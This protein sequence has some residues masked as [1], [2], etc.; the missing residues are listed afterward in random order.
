MKNLSFIKQLLIHNNYPPE[1]IEFHIKKRLKKLRHGCNTTTN[2]NKRN[3]FICLPYVK[4]LESFINN[5]FKQHNTNV[6]YSTKNKLNNIIKL[7]KD[8]TKACDNMNVIYKIK[9]SASYVGQTG[10]RLNIRIKEHAKKYDMQDDN[11]SLYIR[12]IDNNHTI[13]LT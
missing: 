1:L 7:G 9:C 11:S 6:V 13:F 12:K 5:F 10:R 8:K 2:K 3:R 4:E